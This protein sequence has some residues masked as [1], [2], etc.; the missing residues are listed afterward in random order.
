MIKWLH[1]DLGNMAS[2]DGIALQYNI[3]NFVTRYDPTKPND[4]KFKDGKRVK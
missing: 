3:R 1:D 2:L 4:I